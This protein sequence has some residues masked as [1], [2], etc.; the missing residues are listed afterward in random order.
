MRDSLAADS[1][2]FANKH[3]LSSPVLQSI[4]G[5]NAVRTWD[6]KAPGSSREYLHEVKG[7]PIRYELYVSFVISIYSDQCRC[8][9]CS[10]FC[11]LP[12]PYD[13]REDTNIR[14][15]VSL[16]QTYPSTSPPQLQLLSLYIGA[17]GVDA[18]LFGSVLRTFMSKGGIGWSPDNV[19]VFDGMESVRDLC[20]RWYTERLHEK[21]T[22][23]IRSGSTNE[24]REESSLSF[25][26]TDRI[27]DY[28]K[29]TP[30]LLPTGIVILEAEPIIDRKSAFIG[31]AC[32][33]TDPSQVC[34]RLLFSI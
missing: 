26:T 15:L 24:T 25:E 14:V 34:F 30:S 23:E 20:A 13:E 17:F 7:E 33:I 31:R 10:T 9:S 6:T 2:L 18:G 1:N 3:P 5:E 16:P 32:H 11:R 12:P 27:T 8:R 4:Y 29:F 28:S 21:N 19:C 22:S